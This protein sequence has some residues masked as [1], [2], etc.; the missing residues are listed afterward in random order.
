[1][2]T[3]TTHADTTTADVLDEAGRRIDHETPG[4]YAGTKTALDRVSAVVER[5]PDASDLMVSKADLRELLKLAT[6]GMSASPCAPQTADTAALDR[7]A[8]KLDTL[9]TIAQAVT[10][11]ADDMRKELDNV[12]RALAVLREDR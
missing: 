2:T 12:E 4:A 11:G 9:R 7:L 5:F 3:S 1:M 6:A 10:S 8:R